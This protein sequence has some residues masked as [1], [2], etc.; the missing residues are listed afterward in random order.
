MVTVP[1]KSICEILAVTCVFLG[2][3]AV[4]VDMLEA[5]V[6]FCGKVYS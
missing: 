4:G 5:E 2:L 6:R 1:S 3:F